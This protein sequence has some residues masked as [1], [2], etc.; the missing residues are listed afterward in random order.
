MVTRFQYIGFLKSFFTRRFVTLNTSSRDDM[1]NVMFE[2]RK[3][4]FPSGEPILARLKSGVVLSAVSTPFVPSMYPPQPASPDRYNNGARKNKKKK[5]NNGG[6]KSRTN[7][8]ANNQNK[9]AQSKS[10]SPRSRNSAGKQQK[11]PNGQLR[12]S[13]SNLAQQTPP[14]LGEEHFPTLSTDDM[15]QNKIEL[16]KVPD[17]TSLDDSSWDDLGKPKAH[18]DSA[19]TATTSSSSSSSKQSPQVGGYAAALKKAAPPQPA[20]PAKKATEKKQTKKE[21]NAKKSSQGE[22]AKQ[23]TEPKQETTDADSAGVGV[24]P[25]TWGGGRTFADLLRKESMGSSSEQAV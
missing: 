21:T 1:V 15:N 6:A 11:K 5:N 23:S 18:S 14:A 7:G 19:S 10:G 22:K 24:Q 2:L 4:K 8:N 17:H 3:L 9:K 13:L 12:Q 16:E 20:E 25:P